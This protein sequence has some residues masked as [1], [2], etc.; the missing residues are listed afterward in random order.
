[1][2]RQDFPF[3]PM[4]EKEIEMERLMAEMR[5]A[6]LGGGMSMH[7]P[8]ELSSMYNFDDE[9][10]G[11][12]EEDGEDWMGETSMMDRNKNEMFSDEKEDSFENGMKQE[13][14][15]EFDSEF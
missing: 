2:N 13:I 15:D 8:D 3:L 12:G 4:T 6:G 5:A 9:Q 7:T 1:M 11:E 14:T 10:E